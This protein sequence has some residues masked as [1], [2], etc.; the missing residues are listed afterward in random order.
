MID[1]ILFYKIASASE[2]EGCV[3][4]NVLP[5][6]SAEKKIMLE[7]GNLEQILH[8]LSMKKMRAL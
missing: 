8:M 5:L 4:S 1:T 3:Y 7:Y 6:C 2:P